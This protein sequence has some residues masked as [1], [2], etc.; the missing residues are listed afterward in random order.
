MLKALLLVLC[1]TLFGSLIT[2]YGRRQL[3]LGHIDEH[4]E[5]YNLF[6]PYNQAPVA[7]D[8]KKQAGLNKQLD[9][10]E[11]ERINEQL[12]EEVRPQ[13]AVATLICF[14]ISLLPAYRVLRGASLANNIAVTVVVVYIAISVWI[15]L[16]EWLT[17][18]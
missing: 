17:Y 7:E 6:I 1:V 3:Q 13:M 15:R 18:G 9:D 4:L 2:F 5:Y 14:V 12:T 16:A 8:P 11:R 10:W